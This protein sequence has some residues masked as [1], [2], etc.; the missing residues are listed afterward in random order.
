[1]QKPTLIVSCTTKKH[2]QDTLLHQSLCK[3]QTLT[4]FDTQW[5]CENQVG[6]SKMYNAAFKDHAKNYQRIVYIHDDVALDDAML[7]SKLDDAMNNL[8]YDIV[9][10]AGGLNPT[11]QHPAL[12][13]IMSKREHQRGY[14]GHLS[15]DGFKFMTGF[16][17]TPSRVAIVDGLFVAVNV[18]AAMQKNWQWNE[19]FDFHHYDIASCIDANKCSMRVGVYPI[20]V[21]HQS[22]GLL[23][24][25]DVKWSASN[26]KFLQLYS[27][28]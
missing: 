1:M 24:L 22:P 13:H 21:F 6:L 19:N 20:N 2:S 25:D 14:A 27:Q 9:G 18:A 4:N 28:Q 5:Y 3:M 26:K 17:T 10:L 12:W 15:H 7:D 8:N 16:G 23:S 11:I